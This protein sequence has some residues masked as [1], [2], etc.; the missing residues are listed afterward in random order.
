M[1]Q[2]NAI[3]M[4]QQHKMQIDPRCVAVNS[5][6]LKPKGE[7]LALTDTFTYQTC[8]ISRIPIELAVDCSSSGA[9]LQKERMQTKN[10]VI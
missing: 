2:G 5:V 4:S 7:G 8:T 3:D 1:Q 6:L 9:S 10:N